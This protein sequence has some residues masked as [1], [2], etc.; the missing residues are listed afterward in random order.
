MRFAN[1]GKSFHGVEA[2][3]W[4]ST[5]IFIW[6]DTRMAALYQLKDDSATDQ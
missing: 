6:W 4:L 5:A 1:L 3:T 2:S